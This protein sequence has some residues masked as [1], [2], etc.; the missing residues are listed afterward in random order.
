MH[1]DAVFVTASQ[2]VWNNFTESLGE[3]ALIHPLYRSMYLL[4]ASGDTSACVSRFLHEN[5]CLVARL[6]IKTQDAEHRTAVGLV[7][8]FLLIFRAHLSD[9]RIGNEQTLLA[10][11]YCN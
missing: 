8:A 11:P 1:N 3:Q 2:V 7:R 5:W 4:L 9:V 6:V 10:V